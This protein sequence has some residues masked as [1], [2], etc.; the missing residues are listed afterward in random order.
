M[1]LGGS[2]Y[3]VPRLS[4]GCLDYLTA[5]SLV[6]VVLPHVPVLYDCQVGRQDQGTNGINQR[7]GGLDHH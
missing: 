6:I 5:V 4:T 7:L 3:W 2:R 1:G